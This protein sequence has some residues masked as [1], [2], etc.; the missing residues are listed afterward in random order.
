MKRLGSIEGGPCITSR[1]G[2]L[3]RRRFRVPYQVYCKLVHMCIDKKLFGESSARE[4]DIAYRLIC[5]VEIKMLSVLRI[6]GQN[7]N[8]DDIAE[9]TLMGETTARRAFDSFCENLVT[10]FYDAYVT[11]RPKV[12]ESYG[13][14]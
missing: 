4:F 9:A 7:W 11:K 5:P 1:T 2:K 12:K 3:F 8:F 13:G 6:L 14:I 10:H